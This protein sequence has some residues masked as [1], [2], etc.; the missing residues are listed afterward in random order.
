MRITK[1]QLRQIIRESCGDVL[2]LEPSAMLPD[3]ED[4]LALDAEVLPSPDPMSVA[5]ELKNA[6]MTEQD[7]LEWIQELVQSFLSDSMFSF[8]GDVGELPGDEAFGVGYEAGSRGL[9]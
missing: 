3:L 5:E 1:R 9:S 7:V 8:T 6:G 2:D 4:N